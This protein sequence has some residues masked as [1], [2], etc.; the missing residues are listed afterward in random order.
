MHPG[1]NRSVDY[2][3]YSTELF[4]HSSVQRAL[5]K[6]GEAAFDAPAGTADHG[7]PVAALYAW[8]FPNLMLNFYPWGLSLNI[9]EPQG[10]SATRVRF[11]SYVGD[12]TKLHG[13][14]GGALDRVEAVQ[15]GVRSRLYRGGRYSP[16]RERSVHHFHRLLAEFLEK[17]GV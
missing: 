2:A 7:E 13:G 11:R 6:P 9:V 8:V 5:A 10:P 15:R 4:R 16:T 1:L 3:S 14:A 12:V 17:N